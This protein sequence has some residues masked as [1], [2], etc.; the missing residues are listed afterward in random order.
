VALA[1]GA[2]GL[3]VACQGGGIP[4]EEV[5]S[6]LIAFSYRTPEDARTRADDW[7]AS[8]D[9]RV[10][11]ARKQVDPERAAPRS[12]GAIRARTT[13]VRDLFDKLVG[14]T[15]EGPEQYPGRLAL[16]DPRS[17]A[18]TVVD[19]ARR[20]SV[21]L[22]W[23]A[24]R[25]RLLYAQ[26]NERDFQIFEYERER[27]T[28]RP[29]THGPPAHAQACY[30]ADER[31]VVV[32]AEAQGALRSRIE[33][34][35]PGGRKPFTPVT[36]WGLHHSPTCARDGTAAVWVSESETTG[37]SDLV[38]LDPIEGGEPRLLAPGRFPRF[39]PDGAWLVYSAPLQGSWRMWRMRPD[40]SGRAPIGTGSRTESRPTVSPDGR[41]VV[42]V[43]AEQQPRHH[44]Y[45][46]RFDGTGDRILFADG[47]GEYPV[48]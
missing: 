7:K 44:L 20:G 28:V 3:A 21:P 38:I 17:G 35:R 36:D 13:Q 48:W 19:A 32:T 2:L 40:G 6:D 29:L 30:A 9:K 41:F 24:D 47:D 33:V 43:A 37:R 22:T 12:T 16:L 18:I 10:D 23:S 8:R 31:I 46:R 34:S 4:G 25:T 1:L 27:G 11:E 14:R 26:P 5:P 42:Y 45:L 39:S 15:E